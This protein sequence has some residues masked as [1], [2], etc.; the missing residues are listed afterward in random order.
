MKTLPQQEQWQSD[1]SSQKGRVTDRP[2]KGLIGL[3]PNASLK[4]I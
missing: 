2:N 3:G 4:D 1:T